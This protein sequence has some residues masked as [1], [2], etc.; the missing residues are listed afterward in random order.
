MNNKEINQ[1]VELLLDSI[2]NKFLYTDSDYVIFD[3]EDIESVM[4]DDKNIY[5]YQEIY[6][7]LIYHLLKNK[8]SIYEEYFPYKGDFKSIPSGQLAILR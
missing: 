4:E 8:Y 2:E 5:N 1:A 7:I 6:R 3:L